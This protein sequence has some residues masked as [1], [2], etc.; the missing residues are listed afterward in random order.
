MG[1]FKKIYL[2]WNINKKKKLGI[3]FPGEISIS[4]KIQID[5]MSV[6]CL[7]QLYLT[8]SI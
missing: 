8:I 6:S 4:V 7:R 1:Y 2:M 3:T 5:P